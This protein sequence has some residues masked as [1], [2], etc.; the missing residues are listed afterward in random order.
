[1]LNLIHRR[2]LMGVAA[3]SLILTACGG[4]DGGDTPQP[5]PVAQETISAT[6]TGDQEAPSR[7]NSGATGT[8]TFSLIR[9]TRTLSGTVKIDGIANPTAAHLHVGAA[10]E[11]GAVA[12]PLT[13]SETKEVS[14]AS[15]VLTIDQ[16]ATLDAGQFYVNVHSAAFPGGEIRGQVGREVFA[17]QLGG[18]QEV[19]PTSSTATGSGFL[20]LNPITRAISG[21]IE[22]SGIDATAAHIHSGAVGA[23]GA[24]LVTLID[25]GGHG[26]FTVPDNTV[27]SAADMDTLRKGGLYFNAHSAAFPTGEIRG[28]IGRRVLKASANGLQEVPSNPSVATGKATLV[29]DPFTRSVTGNFTLSDLVATI[30]HIHVEAAGANGPVAVPLAESMPGSGVW[31]IPANTVLDAPKAQALLSGGTYVNAHSTAFPAGEIR[32]QVGREVFTA[33]L[34]GTQE[35][36]KVVTAASGI[37]LVVVDPATLSVSVDL[38][39]SGIAA[40]A[41][42]VHAGAIG[43]DGAIQFPVTVDGTGNRFTLSGAT[44]S[45]WQLDS[46]RSGDLYLNAHSAAH[47]SGEIRGQLGVRVFSATA[48]GANEVPATSSAATGRALF[49]LHPDTGELKGQYAVNGMAATLAHIHMGDAGVNGPVLLG[50][51]ETAPQSGIFGPPKGSVLSAA[52]ASALI[53]GGLYVNAHSANFPAGEVR[54]QLSLDK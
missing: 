49:S 54:G 34:S 30:A 19:D 46:L 23:N 28:Q 35:T 8:A 41:A 6:L 24:I 37:G 22:L 18:E 44:L 5:T 27:L 45:A 15:T 20:V 12:I 21:E 9:A 3:A 16:L 32:G 25:H 48:G 11:A 50:L 39:L 1:M 29:Y 17:A 52:Q 42:H 4:G 10:G 2:A 47:P 31:T 53:G 51:I 7:T 33:N 40:T 38:K 36:A 43:T 26:H 14:L 13:I